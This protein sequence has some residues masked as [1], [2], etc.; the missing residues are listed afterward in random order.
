MHNAVLHQSP[1]TW[2]TRHVANTARHPT[3]GSMS[4]SLPC[5]NPCLLRKFRIHILKYSPAHSQFSHRLL[6][7]HLGNLR[8][9]SSGKEIKCTGNLFSQNITFVGNRVQTLDFQIIAPACVSKQFD[10]TVWSARFL[11]LHLNTLC[12]DKQWKPINRRC[13]QGVTR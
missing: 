3:P 11:R 10:L 1:D 12:Y 9:Y 4:S 8:I 5:Q 7:R 6:L 13:C 2:K